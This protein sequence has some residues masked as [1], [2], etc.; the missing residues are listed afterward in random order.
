MPACAAH[1]MP[2][3]P[4][5]ITM[6]S[7]D[8]A[9]PAVSVCAL[10]GIAKARN[11]QL[12]RN[13]I[14]ATFSR[15]RCACRCIRGAITL[16]LEEFA[17]LVEPVFR[18]RIVRAR[19]L[20][21]DRF[22]FAQELF[23]PRGQ[24]H[25]RFD[26]DMAEQVAVSA[27]AHPFDPLA[28]QSK[29]LPGLRL[30]WNLELGV[31]LER[32]NLDLAA[33]RSDCE[34]DRHL[35][36]KI[37]V[38]AL[39]YRVLLQIYD[40]VKI[41][42]RTAIEPSL[43]FA[44][45]PDAIVVIDSGRDLDRQGLALARAA[46]AAAR[47]ARLGNDL[48]GAATLRARLLNGEKT[49]RDANLALAVAGRAGLGLRSRLGAAAM[50]GLALLHRRNADL[51]FGAARGL[52]QRKLE[53]VAKVGAPIDAVAATTRAS[54]IAEDVAEDIAKSIGETAEAFGAAAEAARTRGAHG[55]IDSGMP[56][57]I[58]RR[59][60]AR[61]GED[62]VRFLGLLEFL[63]RGLV[64][65]IAVGMVLHRQLAI[66]LLDV[67]FRSVA[68]DAQGRVIVALSHSSVS[69]TS[70]ANCVSLTAFGRVK[71]RLEGAASTRPDI[72]SPGGRDVAHFLGPY[73]RPVTQYHFLSL[74][75]VNSA[76]TTF[77][78][79]PP[80]A[81]PACSPPLGPCGFADACASACDCAYIAS[82]SFC[83]AAISDCA[84]ASI[85]SLLAS[86]S[87][88]SSSASF[89]ADSIL[90]FSSAATLSPCSV[91]DFCTL[92]TSASR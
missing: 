32:G 58:V 20:R 77:S 19:V 90:P 65:R 21:V 38:L 41:A 12:R 82:P 18:A 28:T 36:M 67:L 87:F 17:Y 83:D 92:W 75:S 71:R 22:E 51:G 73:A 50:A 15:L 54:L 30:G 23:L 31:S 9:R 46:D 84:L 86:L 26:R 39:E 16:R 3:A 48:S 80:P 78:S 79:P 4:A 72:A 37:I 70:V 8:A 45:K 24:L 52:F 60:L 2:A 44:R 55:R 81:P 27:A 35:A 34:P 74:T 14:S 76:S 5:P 64:I 29:D 1:I 11:A 88:R 7:Y 47:R 61:I 59:A 91:K 25:R 53:V 49:L 66:S 33:H 69:P 42:M 62:F 6:T 40:D 13:V 85:A 10:L 68:I 89:N 57:L 43:A 56:E 63:F